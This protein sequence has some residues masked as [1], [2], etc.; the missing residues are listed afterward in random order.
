MKQV[1]SGIDNVGVYLDDIGVFCNTW[2]EHQ[3][4]LDNVLS[5]LEEMVSLS[6]PS[7]MNGPSMNSNG[8]VIN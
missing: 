6:T 2:E 4:L 7:N 3:V 5:C 1:F 8:L